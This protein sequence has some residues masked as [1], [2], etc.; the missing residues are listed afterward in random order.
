M[1]AARR[2]AAANSGETPLGRLDPPALI[3]KALSLAISTGNSSLVMIW[4]PGLEWH[5]IIAGW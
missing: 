1:V 3:F 5:W 2:D 4:Y